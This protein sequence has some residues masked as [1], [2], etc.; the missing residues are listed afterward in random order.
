MNS[1]NL[2]QSKIYG[3]FLPNNLND[4]SK[5]AYTSYTILKKV[6]IV[7]RCRIKKWHQFAV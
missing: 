2:V 1:I 7:Y 5:R 6:K 3:K 4:L